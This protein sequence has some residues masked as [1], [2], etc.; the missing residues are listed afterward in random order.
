M[1]S[2]EPNDAFNR[3]LA[4]MTRP[5]NWANPTPKERYHLVV[6]GGGPA[7][8]VCAAGAAG[9]GAKVALV[10]R[11]RLGGDCLHFGCVPSKALLR[12]ARAAADVRRASEFGIV[13]G[14]PRVDFGAV[15]ERMRRLRSSLADADSAERFKNLGVDVFFGDGS[16]AG[17]ETIAV[18][19]AKLRF[20]RAV[21]ATGARP[22]D[23]GLPGLSPDNYFTNETIFNLTQLPARLLVLGAGP[24]GCELAQAFARLGS[25]VHLINRSPR[26]LAREDPAA[27]EVVRRALER[28][29]VILHLGVRLI[30]GGH[31]FLRF[32]ENGQPVR[33]DADT[34]LVAVGRRANVE[35]LNLAAAG[36][37]TTERG[38]RVDDRLRTTNRRVSA[39]GDVCSSYQYTHA[40]DTMARL[41]L[42]NA[43]YFGRRRV[44]AQVIPHCTYTDPEIASVGLTG[45][46]EARQSDIAIDTIYV[47]LAE[48]DRAVL[49]GE[50]NGIAMVHLRAGTDRLVGATIV[51]AHAGDLVGELVQAMALNIR[52]GALA[53]V[54]RPYPTQSEVWKKVA[55]AYQRS[56]LT[57][58]TS[59]FLRKVLKLR[60]LLS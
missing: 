25:E 18:A 1:I 49:D 43:L 35:N 17:P 47:P 46:E 15:M 59:W 23:P 28:D 36:I 26:I 22:A 2:A 13:A 14:E 30:D 19:G 58:R 10:E 56:R 38:I 60:E 7:G 40:A 54:V 31:N 11:Y 45:R 3:D 32:E 12:C 37:E 55:D 39:A 53:G 44:S 52:L 24:I 21:I 51:A 5:P 27:A 50:T 6:L 42:R 16:F 33:L 9:L 8:L 29:R 4:A 20:L 34:L 41:V 57:P 48:V